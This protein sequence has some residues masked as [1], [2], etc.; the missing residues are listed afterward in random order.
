MARD[1]NMLLSDPATGTLQMDPD[2]RMHDLATRNGL[3]SDFRFGRVAL[4]S[5]TTMGYRGEQIDYRSSLPQPDVIYE[6]LK[7][8]YSSFVLNHDRFIFMDIKSAEND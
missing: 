6:I 5:T 4:H 3:E 7:D 1:E 2:V 8:L